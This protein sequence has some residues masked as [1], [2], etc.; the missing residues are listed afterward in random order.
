MPTMQLRLEPT[1]R[2][3]GFFNVRV[4]FDRFVTRD[5]RPIDLYLGDA[6]EPVQ[7]RVDRKAN[8]NGTARIHGRKPLREYFQLF[9]EG[10]H[11]E[12]EMPSAAVMR[13]APAGS[14]RR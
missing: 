3:Q 5:E 10:A 7:G 8:R 9:R 14:G 6:S 11:L 13:I 2:K 12:V 4:D 1:Y